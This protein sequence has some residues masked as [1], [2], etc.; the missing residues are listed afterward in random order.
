[1]EISFSYVI[2]FIS[3]IYG[4]ALA[5]GLSCIAEYIQRW[6]EIK[7]YWVWW[8]WAIWLLMLSVGF[9]ISI[10]S[11]YS[12]IDTWNVIYVFFLT[13]QA[14]LFYLNY[15]IFFNHYDEMENGDLEI[16]FYKYKKPYY[17]LV[18]IQ[19]NLMFFGTNLLTTD[20]MFLEI[21]KMNIPIVA[22]S[23]ILTYLAFSNNKKIHKFFAFIFLALFIIQIISEF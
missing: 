21:F 4:L 9:W 10:Y 14:S 11:F 7:Q 23:I 8:F 3:L 16:E 2:T 1:M 18:I 22:Y 19:L 12:K 6:K 20:K 15:Y 13:L 17:F 5:H